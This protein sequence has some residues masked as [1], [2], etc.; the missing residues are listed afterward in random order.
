MSADRNDRVS[1]PP[2]VMSQSEEAEVLKMLI[3]NFPSKKLTA[4]ILRLA[5][6]S[7]ELYKERYMGRITLHF[8]DGLVGKVKRE[9]YEDWRRS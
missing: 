4:Q 3:G 8:G 5:E 7:V 1:S 9:K 6:M 2:E